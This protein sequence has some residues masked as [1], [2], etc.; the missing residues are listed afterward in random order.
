MSSWLG[1]FFSTVQC[2][3]KGPTHDDDTTAHENAHP[4]G[5][6]ITDAEEKEEKEE[7]IKEKAEEE[8]EEK[9]EEEEEEEPE[10]VSLQWSPC[11][12]LLS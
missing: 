12:S 2:E 10:D 6:G 3:D 1:S 7:E 11:S 5:K 9:A 4:Q 8:P